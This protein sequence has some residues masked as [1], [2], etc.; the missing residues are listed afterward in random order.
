VPYSTVIAN[1]A[2][3]I[4]GTIIIAA[5]HARKP[6]VSAWQLANKDRPGAVRYTRHALSW[7]GF[8]SS[9]AAGG[10]A[11]AISDVESGDLLSARSFPLRQGLG[12]LL[13]SGHE[14]R[15]HRHVEALYFQSEINIRQDAFSGANGRFHFSQIHTIHLLGISENK[16]FVHWV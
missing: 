12:G 5:T 16:I 6:P 11:L 15:Q 2:S 3:R 9:R 10:A 1:S 7:Q 8:G 13:I 4:M 14:T